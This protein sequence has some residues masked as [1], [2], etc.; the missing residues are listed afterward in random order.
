MAE[1]H[2]LHQA[3]LARMSDLANALDRRGWMD[4]DRACRWLHEQFHPH[5]ER[6]ERDLLPLLEQAGARNLRRQLSAE[7]REMGD[8][9][10][11]LLQGHA[12]GQLQD[13]RH[14]ERARRLLDLVRQH[15]DTEEHF[16]RPLLQGRPA[17]A[18]APETGAGYQAPPYPRA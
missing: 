10:R 14:G 2:R 17:P 11:A 16:M 18:R 3:A 9:T 1:W 15:I 8:L 5:H 7:H 4:V 13:P 6:E 12:G